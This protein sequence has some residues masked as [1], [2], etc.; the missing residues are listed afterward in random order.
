MN[1]CS[2]IDSSLK[3]ASEYLDEVRKEIDYAVH[4]L[5]RVDEDTDI[6]SAVAVICDAVDSLNNA[7]YRIS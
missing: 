5:I 2:D 7:L 3:S 6:L 1:Q 4:A